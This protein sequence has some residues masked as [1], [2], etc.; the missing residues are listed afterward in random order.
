MVVEPSPSRDASLVS[1]SRRLPVPRHGRRPRL[2]RPEHVPRAAAPAQ[3]QEQGRP[4]RVRPALGRPAGLPLRDQLLPD[5]D[6]L[7][8]VRHRGHLPLPGRGAAARVRDASRSSRRSSSSRCCS[9]PSSTS[10][11]EERSNGDSQARDDGAPTDFRV[12]QLRARDMLRGDLDGA[13]L[14]Q[15]VE[16]A[17]SPRRST[18]P[19]A[20]RAATRSSRPPSAWPAARSR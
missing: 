2:R 19:S 9:S 4:V 12:R 11:A 13:D 7:H 17:C 1:A 6:A 16:R 20:G 5:R 14:E 3:G 15:H 10:G 8:P 18:R